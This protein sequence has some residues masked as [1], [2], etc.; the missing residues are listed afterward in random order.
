MNTDRT[1]IFIVMAYCDTKHHTIDLPLSHHQTK[2]GAQRRVQQFMREQTNLS[3]AVERYERDHANMNRLDDLEQAA[4]DFITM[5]DF[6][7]NTWSNDDLLMI[8]FDV[9]E[10]VLEP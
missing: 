3:S 5:L 6:A 4:T 8:E 2:V 1:Q 10:E 7:D 9:V